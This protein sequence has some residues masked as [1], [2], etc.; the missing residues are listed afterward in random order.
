MD[1]REK[2]IQEQRT[3][4]AMKKGYIGYEGKFAYIAKKLGYPIISHGGGNY[5]QTFLD[6]FYDFND[7]NDDKNEL[8]IMDE[9]ESISEIGMSYEGLQFGNNLTIILLYGN[10]DITVRHE[11]NLVYK[12]VAG[13]LEGFVPNEKWENHIDQMY[14][15]A[16]KI[17]KKKRPLENVDLE[18]KAN[19][20]KKEILDDL[21]KKWGI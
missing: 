12:E 17:E 14:E 11:S 2:L 10:A 15:Y 20:K 3:I 13:E 7:S 6:D 18:K 9:N 21:K 5:N 19:K 8:P 4:E 1:N 16:K